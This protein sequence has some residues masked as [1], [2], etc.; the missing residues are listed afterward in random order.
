MTFRMRKFGERPPRERSVDGSEHGYEKLG[1][2][3][4]DA[5]QLRSPQAMGAIRDKRTGSWISSHSS[6][7]LGI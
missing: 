6:S 1:R 5:S 7:S 4:G 2:F 3:E